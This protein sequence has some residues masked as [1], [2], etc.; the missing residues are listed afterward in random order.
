ME[1]KTSRHTISIERP[2]IMAILNVTPD[3]FFDGGAYLSVD[4]ALRQTEK[5]IADGADII[6][7]GGES[8]RPGSE[9][10]KVEDEIARVA[11]VIAGIAKHFETPISID[12][13]KS[14]V[15]Q[16]AI[17]AGAE[18]INDISGLRFDEGIA[19]VAARH[20]TG[21]ILMHSRGTFE[22]LHSQPPVDNIF[23]DVEADFRRALDV[24]RLHAVE[25]EQIVLD[26]GIGFGKT[27]EQN[28]ELIAKLDRLVN[29][30]QEYPMLVGAS[31]KSFLG[32]DVPPAERLS[33]SVAAAMLAVKNGAKVVRVHDVK[34]T[35]AALGS[36]GA[37][38]TLK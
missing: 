30:F 12:T 26:V 15:A 32:L 35:V 3:S 7:I 13:T 33:G 28:L 10:V 24:A 11:P 1:W 4:D 27:R 9:P 2:L 18:I 29:E 25:D 16:Q 14:A 22:T 37:I 6:D 5:M 36:V 31:R 23:A 17:D 20:G 34:E 21:L 19:E 8:T 38:E